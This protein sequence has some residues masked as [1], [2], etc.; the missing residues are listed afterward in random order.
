[1]NP[2]GDKVRAVSIDEDD[3]SLKALQALSRRELQSVAKRHGCK[4][5]AKSCDIIAELCRDRDSVEAAEAAEPAAAVAKPP[6]PEGGERKKKRKAWQMPVEHVCLPEVSGEEPPSA[7]VPP[8][9]PTEAAAF[10]LPLSIV[11][12]ADVERSTSLGLLQSP[13]SPPQ[14][15]RPLP[16]P[17]TSPPASASIRS[18]LA[19]E[20]AASRCAA[21]TSGRAQL[22]HLGVV[23]SYAANA[24]QEVAAASTAESAAASVSAAKSAAEPTDALSGEDFLAAIHQRV[25]VLAA[26]PAAKHGR[27]RQSLSSLSSTLLDA[28][29]VSRSTSQ[30]TTAAVAAAAVAEARGDGA[31]GVG[32]DCP[33]AA[34]PHTSLLASPRP[35]SLPRPTS[36]PRSSPSARPSPTFRRPSSAMSSAI[37]K[38]S[39][40][41]GSAS[42]RPP[43]GHATEK[44]ALSAVKLSANKPRWH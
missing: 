32:S 1:M 16:P 8:P 18:A 31:A 22:L 33:A 6:S 30:A 14:P 13:P 11:E 36:L 37:C 43:P 12:H 9:L 17:L 27:L 19:C 44:R 15:L 29:I 20:A 5:N 40:C 41:K 10:R 25:A 23:P 7:S 2:D 38:K 42:A 21:A 34:V 24:L 28:M 39:S 26:S 4:A 35:S 3:L